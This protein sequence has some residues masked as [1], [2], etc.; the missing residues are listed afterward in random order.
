MK[1]VEYLFPEFSNLYADSKNIEY[2]SK[3]NKK[4]KVVY[5]HASDE[6]IFVRKKVDMIYMGSMPDEKVPGAIQLL[7][8]YKE[9]IKELIED[10]VIFLITGNSL[11]VFGSYIKEG[12]KRIDGLGIFDYYVVKDM[13]NKHAS[14]FLGEY[15]N[16]YIVGHRNQFSKV[17]DIKNRF[18]KMKG[19]YGI[20]LEGANEGICYKNF[21]ATF[22]LGPLLIL[23]P[24]FTKYLLKKLD[25]DDSLFEEMII[26]N[27]Y[28]RRIS[29]FR[30]KDARFDIGQYG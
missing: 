22:L 19:G 16:I 12:N 17:Y 8:V 25:L 5:T 14:W 27:A 2:L 23:N 1:T 6:P 24:V 9:R 26:M 29:H 20:D 11:E 13:E 21:Y 28:E 3:C 30:K 15:N 10:G 4:I 18:I 7:S